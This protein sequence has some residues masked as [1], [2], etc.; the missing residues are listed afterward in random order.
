MQSIGTILFLQVCSV[1][2][3]ICHQSVDP[4]SGMPMPSITR[5]FPVRVHIAIARS[6]RYPMAVNWHISSVTPVPVAA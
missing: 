4:H 6:L 3:Q 1:Q 2:C 5:A